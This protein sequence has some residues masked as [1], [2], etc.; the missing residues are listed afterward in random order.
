MTC[1][2]GHSFAKDVVFLRDVGMHS[3]SDGSQI[4]ISLAADAE[5]VSWQ[6]RL[7]LARELFSRS[8]RVS[9]PRGHQSVFGDGLQPLAVDPEL[10]VDQCDGDNQEEERVA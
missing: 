1:L 7:V 6:A 2:H 5:M 3:A 9:D 8:E 4:R 10:T